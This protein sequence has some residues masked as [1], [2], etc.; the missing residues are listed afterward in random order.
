MTD[1]W[2]GFCKLTKRVCGTNLKAMSIWCP[3]P[4]VVAKNSS[5][6][7]VE[8]HTLPFSIILNGFTKKSRSSGR[9]CIALGLMHIRQIHFISDPASLYA[10]ITP[11]LSAAMLCWSHNKKDIHTSSVFLANVIR[12]H[13]FET[14]LSP[15]LHE[16]TTHILSHRPC[17]SRGEWFHQRAGWCHT[18]TRWGFN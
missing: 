6:A 9:V 16:A 18:S 17:W 15:Q 1:H 2:I 5:L 7:W 10:M 8:L 3:K 13:L 4:G 11:T 12:S 14:D